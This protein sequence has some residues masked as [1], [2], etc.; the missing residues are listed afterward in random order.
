[1]RGGAAAL[2]LAVLAGCGETAPPAGPRPGGAPGT[3][4]AAPATATAA[5]RT[6]RAPEAKLASEGQAFPEIERLAPPPTEGLTRASVEK[7]VD[8]GTLWV[9]GG[10]KLKLVGILAPEGGEPLAEEATAFAR[11]LLGRPVAYALGVPP[12]DTWKRG[13]AY[14]FSEGTLVNG[15]L[16]RRGLAYFVV[17]DGSAAYSAAL[18]ALEQAAQRDGL[19]LWSLPPPAPAASYVGDERAP[20]FHRPECAAAKKIAEARRVAWASREQAFDAG[21]APCRDCKP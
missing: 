5:P 8:A 16:V 13:L 12:R 6:R 2:V 15:A 9:T 1:M 19:G 11:A 20:F 14:V 4:A 3:S 7:V 18:L 21:R 17:G 10:V